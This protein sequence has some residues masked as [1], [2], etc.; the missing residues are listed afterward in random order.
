MPSLHDRVT[1][2][3]E[4]AREDVY[5]YVL[6]LGLS[7][8]QAQEVAQEVFLRLYT[9]LRDGNDIQNDRA[10]IFRVA[11]NQALKMRTK[12]REYSTID[13]QAEVAVSAAQSPEQQAIGRQRDRRIR[14][15]LDELSPQQRQCLHLRAS[16]LRYREIAET[17]GIG[18][19]TVNE[20]LRRAVAKLRKALDE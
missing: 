8:A 12:E 3:Y 17:I 5:Y 2:A 15:A 13:S 6:T 4:D 9:T 10:W 14:E 18:T 20:F 19:S 16:G 1:A 11:H 7:P